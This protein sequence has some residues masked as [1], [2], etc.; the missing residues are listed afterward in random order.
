MIYVPARNN[1]A[2]LESR[3]CEL[4]K[5]CEFWWNGPE[6]LGDCKNWPEKPDITNKDEYEKERKMVSELLATTVDLQNSI[7]TLLNKFTLCKTLRIL[8]W[9]NRFLNNCKKS[10]VSGPLTA[11]KVLV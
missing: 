7:D 9:I 11:D 2:D 5:L 4:R 6:W 8:S 1:P 3:C 10:K